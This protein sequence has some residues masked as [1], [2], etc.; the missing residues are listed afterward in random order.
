M[1][2]NTHLRELFQA[3]VLKNSK[4]PGANEMWVW[5]SLKLFDIAVEVAE[6]TLKEGELLSESHIVNS[7]KLEALVS[8]ANRQGGQDGQLFRYL[9][10]LPGFE[11]DKPLG[12]ETERQHIYLLTLVQNFLM[13]ENS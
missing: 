2:I 1:I 6:A 8:F 3:R 10:D 11:W 5:R 7:A 4:D 12:A 13:I 9:S